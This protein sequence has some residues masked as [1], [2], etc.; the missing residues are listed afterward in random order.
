MPCHVTQVFQIQLLVIQFIIK[1][2]RI[3]CT[4]VLIL[5][6]LKSQYYKIIKILKLYYLQ[7]KWAKIILLLQ[8]S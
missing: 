4:Q 5:Q 1:M 3:G 2:F 7:K 8:L 6:S